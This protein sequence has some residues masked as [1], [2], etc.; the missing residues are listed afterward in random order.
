LKFSTRITTIEVLNL[1]KWSRCATV[2]SKEKRAWIRQFLSRNNTVVYWSGIQLGLAFV[3]RFLLWTFS[4]NITL[5]TTMAS[6][7]QYYNYLLSRFPI[8]KLPKLYLA[9]LR[10]MLYVIPGTQKSKYLDTSSHM[11]D[12]IVSCERRADCR[13]LPKLEN[14]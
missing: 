4:I 1:G 13:I 5:V 10:I 2:Q 6:I 11:C 8:I 12:I 7:G 14:L 3:R 9:S